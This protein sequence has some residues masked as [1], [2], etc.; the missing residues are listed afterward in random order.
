MRVGGVAPCT[1]ADERAQAVSRSSSL[2]N[3]V[4]TTLITAVAT[5]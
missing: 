5:R 2:M 4:A 3:S 1:P